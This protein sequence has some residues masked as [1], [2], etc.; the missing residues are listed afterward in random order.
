MAPL[1]HDLAGVI[2]PHD[3]IGSHLNSRAET[4]DTQLEKN[5]FV[6]AGQTIASIW[7]DTVIDG[8]ETVAEY[9]E[10]KAENSE[11]S[12]SIQIGAQWDVEHI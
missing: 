12:V 9:K 1:S 10:P 5:N 4:T 7:S 8:F 6:K 11:K 3:Q 2:L